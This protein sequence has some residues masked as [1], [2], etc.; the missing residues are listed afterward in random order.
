M[1]LQKSI[2]AGDAGL[3]DAGP[4]DAVDSPLNLPHPT[5]HDGV[6]SINFEA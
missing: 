6:G 2:T 5:S 4:T 3:R 1:M